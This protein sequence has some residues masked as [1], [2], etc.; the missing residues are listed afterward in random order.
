MF[1]D[2]HPHIVLF[3]GCCSKL[4]DVCIVTEFMPKGS[5]FDVLHDER[6]GEGQKGMRT[7]G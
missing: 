7:R 3:M 2:R 1:Y 6:Y 4:P 5:L